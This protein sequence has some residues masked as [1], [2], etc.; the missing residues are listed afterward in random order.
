MP[1]SH[2]A[3]LPPAWSRKRR[4]AIQ[5]CANVSAVRSWAAS[6]VAGAAQVVRVDGGGVPL[7]EPAER[8]RV[9]CAR[10]S[11]SASV[12]MG[13]GLPSGCRPTH[14]AGGPVVTGRP[15]S[16]DGDGPPRPGRVTILLCG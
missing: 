2:G 6:G 13:I 16:Y 7:V 14:G 10:R 1:N 12:V 11:S 3:A 4:R 9:A 15:R 8:R 5:A